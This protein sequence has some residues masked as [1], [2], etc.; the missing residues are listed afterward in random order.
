MMVASKSVRFLRE[1]TPF[2]VVRGKTHREGYVRRT[3]IKPSMMTGVSTSD[4]V[5]S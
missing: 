5:S 1:I 3:A 2:A 4:F